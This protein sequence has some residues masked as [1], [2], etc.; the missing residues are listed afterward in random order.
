MSA[1]LSLHRAVVPK[2]SALGLRSPVAYPA[3]ASSPSMGAGAENWW[4][5]QLVKQQT[6][7]VDMGACADPHGAFHTVQE[8]CH[9]QFEQSLLACHFQWGS[10]L[11]FTSTLAFSYGPPSAPR[12][13]GP[14]S[15][16]GLCGLRWEAYDPRFNKGTG[17]G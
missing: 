2:D 4:H 7:I 17:G 12:S 1:Y 8:N 13:E 10:V 5:C 15:L 3:L 6:D 14:G 11:G 9:E 16:P